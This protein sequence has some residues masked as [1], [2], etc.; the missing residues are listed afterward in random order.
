[1]ALV[2]VDLEVALKS[3]EGDEAIPTHMERWLIT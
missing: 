1:M 3:W 2:G